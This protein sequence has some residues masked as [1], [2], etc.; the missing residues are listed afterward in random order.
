M[1]KIA[2]Y[3]L[4]RLGKAK[5]EMQRAT[6]YDAEIA[7]ENPAEGIKDLSELLHLDLKI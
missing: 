2:P 5:K 7:F 3:P 4:E 6:E 1:Q